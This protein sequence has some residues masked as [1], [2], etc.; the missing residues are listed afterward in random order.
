M[1]IISTLISS[2]LSIELS[3]L[4]LMSTRIL[5]LVSVNLMIGT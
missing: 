3:T 5:L 1:V 4:K 2:A